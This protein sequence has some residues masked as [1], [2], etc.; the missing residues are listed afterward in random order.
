MEGIKPQAKSI[1]NHLE[2][3]HCRRGRTIRK[4]YPTLEAGF[5]RE[6]RCLEL[7]EPDIA[8]D[9]P[10]N[11]PAIAG[12]QVFPGYSCPVKKEGILC[13]R[14]FRKVGTLYEHVRKEHHGVSRQFPKSRLSQCHCECQTIYRRPIQY[15]KVKTGLL[16][17][18]QASPYSVFLQGHNTDIPSFPHTPEPIR[19]EELPSLLRAT[20]W[21]I[22]VGPY[23]NS[24]KDVVDLIRH[25]TRASKGEVG[26]ED[27]LC[28]LPFISECWIDMVEEYYFNH[29]TEMQERILAGYP[30]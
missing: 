12:L 10:P 27:T 1:L 5:D 13:L 30:M 20:R 28:K 2:K 7:A 24:P 14:T 26:V 29:G 23:R 19:M 11:R 15:F 6:L 9:Q 22:F 17:G 18:G 25:P 4:T 21:D 3:Y 8:K 16:P